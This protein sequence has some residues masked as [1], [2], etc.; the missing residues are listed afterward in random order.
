MTTIEPAGPFWEAEPEHQD[1]LVRI[2][3]GYTCHFVRPGLGAAQARRD[4]LDRDT[5]RDD[6]RTPGGCRS[7]HF[8]CVWLLQTV[9]ANGS[10]S[11]GTASIGSTVLSTVTNSPRAADSCAETIVSSTW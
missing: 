3:H 8:A 2:P 11:T 5:S 7:P 6:G 4:R 9:R 10:K 1:Y